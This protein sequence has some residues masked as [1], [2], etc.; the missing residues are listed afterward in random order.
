M[1]REGFIDEL[2]FQQGPTKQNIS[3]LIKFSKNQVL[4]VEINI[5]IEEKMVDSLNFCNVR[6]KVIAWKFNGAET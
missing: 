1:V 5:Q 6:I 4:E 3:S 2:T